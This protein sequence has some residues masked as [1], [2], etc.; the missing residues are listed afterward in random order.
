[1]AQIFKDAGADYILKDNEDS[2]G[3]TLDFE[4]VYARGINAEFWQIDSSFDGD[5]TLDVLANEDARYAT[6]NAYKNQKVI[7]CNLA[8]TP[9]RE[10]AG[11]QPHFVLADFAKAFH[12]EILPNYQPKFYKLIK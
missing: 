3:T 7:F 5:F 12:P 6:M 8:Q 9:Y 1:M 2:G 10:L 4:A 11:V